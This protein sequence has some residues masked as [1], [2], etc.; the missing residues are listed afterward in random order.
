[1]ANRVDD[2][3]FETG[4]D[5]QEKWNGIRTGLFSQFSEC[6]AVTQVWQSTA[7]TGVYDKY[8][9]DEKPFRTWIHLEQSRE[10]L[11]VQPQQSI[12]VTV[13]VS[14]QS[15]NF[16]ISFSALLY[17]QRCIRLAGLLGYSISGIHNL[18]VTVFGIITVLTIGHLALS[19]FNR[20]RSVVRGI[21]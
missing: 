19:L 21:W 1:M 18:E 8:A 9:K 16:L 3:S 7:C 15:T 20:S 5:T 2:G 17:V 6:S 10:V 12:M 4:S 13:N 11:K 14:N